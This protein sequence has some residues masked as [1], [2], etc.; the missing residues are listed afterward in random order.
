MALQDEFRAALERGDL[1]HVRRIWRHVAPNMPQPETDDDAAI[2][3]HRTRTEAETISF[4]ARAYSHRWLEERAFPSGLPDNLK[5]KA[6]RIYPRTV[7]A[8]GISI[9]TSSPYLR[10]AAIEVR[11]AM[12]SAVEDA[13]ADGRTD[14][15]FV[16]QRM[17]E[18][19]AKAWKQLVG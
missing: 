12:E 11:H 5:P 4:K 17:E 8:V 15:A 9:N 3:M 13:Y 2:A 6:E 14:P 16:S 1:A 19:R 18:A 10:P 7:G